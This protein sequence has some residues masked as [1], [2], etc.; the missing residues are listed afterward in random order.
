MSEGVTT[1]NLRQAYHLAMLIRD[2]N[3]D[4]A[5][6]RDHLNNT[7]ADNG[8][9]PCKIFGQVGDPRDFDTWSRIDFKARHNGT[10]INRNDRGIHAKFTKPAD[11]QIAH[12]GQLILREAST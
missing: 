6:A 9:A 7:D 3:T 4:C 10:W 5:F 1:E 11:Q 8:Q 12:F 2:L